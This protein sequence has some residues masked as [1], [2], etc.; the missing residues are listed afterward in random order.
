M[1][2]E[3]I[4]NGDVDT[5]EAERLAALRDYNILDTPPEEAF[6]RV[7]RLAQTLFGLPIALV[8]LIDEKRQWF[9]A[10]VGIDQQETPRS[11]AFCNHAIQQNA[12]LIIRDATDDARFRDS[13][14]VVNEPR[15]R[16]YAGAPVRDP[17]GNGLGTVC[18]ISPTPNVAFTARDEA[19]L[20]S[21]A[22]IVANEMELRRQLARARQHLADKDMLMREVHFQVANSLQMVADVLDLQAHRAKSPD[23]RLDLGNA[24][25]RVIS[26]GEVHQQLRRQVAG[27]GVNMREYLTALV[28]RIWKGVMPLDGTAGTKV[29]VPA[30]LK[31]DGDPAARVG[32]ATLVLVMNAARFGAVALR[33]A[34]ERDQGMLSLTV[35]YDDKQPT[36]TGYD[37]REHGTGIRLIQILAGDQSISQ[38]KL[39]PR[40]VSVGFNL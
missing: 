18:V 28:T 5:A 13:P 23:A 24:S 3:R 1:T 37:L 20:T 33:V 16:F 19:T 4:S 34:V 10:R 14:L 15:I 8:S 36:P 27:D 40:R 11:W 32:M 26:I 12:P 25:G 31:L 17:K 30:G 6:D 7:V 35:E 38:D 39:D 2:D 29:T 22:G 9:K 21:L